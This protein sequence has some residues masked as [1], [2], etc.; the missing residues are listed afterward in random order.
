MSSAK[1]ALLV[2]VTPPNLAIINERWE[3][4]SSVD[5]EISGRA[6]VQEIASR[7]TEGEDTERE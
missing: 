3:R 4:V 2:D 5:R 7:E 1:P 6:D